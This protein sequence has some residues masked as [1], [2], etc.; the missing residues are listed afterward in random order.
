MHYCMNFHYLIFIFMPPGP[1]T[2]SGGRHYAL[3]D[4]NPTGWWRAVIVVK[5][6]FVQKCSRTFADYNV[7]QLHFPQMTAACAFDNIACFT[8]GS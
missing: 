3:R 8:V 1:A 7:R 4:S 6:L 2:A 5:I